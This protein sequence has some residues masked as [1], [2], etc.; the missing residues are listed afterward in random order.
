[1]LFAPKKLGF[2]VKHNNSI[3]LLPY[4]RIS[5]ALF[6]IC[7]LGVNLITLSLSTAC[8][9]ASTQLRSQNMYMKYFRYINIYKGNSSKSHG[10]A[11]NEVW[12][13]SQLLQRTSNNHGNR[14]GSAMFI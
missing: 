3:I 2:H 13:P 9:P 6:E 5:A 12:P 10:Y 7:V 14:I 1:M 4:G 11:L 8:H